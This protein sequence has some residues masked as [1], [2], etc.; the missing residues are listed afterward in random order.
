MNESVDMTL[1]LGLGGWGA[2]H[3]LTRAWVSFSMGAW[4]QARADLAL[5]A[6]WELSSLHAAWRA[7]GMGYLA[8]AAGDK[9]AADA[10]LAESREHLKLIDT[11]P[12]V[13]SIASAICTVHVLLGEWSAALDA[14]H[15]GA[16]SDLGGDVLVRQWSALAAAPTGDRDLVAAEVAD[17]ELLDD[18]SFANAVRG[19]VRASAAATQGRWDEARSAYASAVAGYLS[20]DMNAEAA[21]VGLEFASY[22]GDRDDDARAAGEVAAAWFGARGASSVVERYRANFA[23]TA[24]PPAAGAGRQTRSIPVDAEQPA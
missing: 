8:A 24:A 18:L 9:P 6:D 16:V 19:H 17:L 15:G 7:G 11:L 1:R 4:D 20:L 22:L 21:L 23:G 12:Q 10:W 5:V 13:A 2:Q 14:V 3:L